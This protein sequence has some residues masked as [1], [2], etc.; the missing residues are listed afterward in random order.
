MRKQVFLTNLGAD[1]QLASGH[2]SDQRRGGSGVGE[3]V[4]FQT[5]V[6]FDLANCRSG[7]DEIVFSEDETGAEVSGDD[8]ADQLIDAGDPIAVRL[9]RRKVVPS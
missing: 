7:S 6:R 9:A 3:V 4:G 2:T 5:R 1:R 8:P